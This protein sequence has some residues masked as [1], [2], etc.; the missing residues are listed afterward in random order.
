MV[1]F[2]SSKLLGPYKK[3]FYHLFS[4]CMYSECNFTSFP[5]Q[6]SHILFLNCVL[7]QFNFNTV[8][9]T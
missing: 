5:L 6:R 1:I 8:E 2:Q 9:S 7:A 4:M 3:Q